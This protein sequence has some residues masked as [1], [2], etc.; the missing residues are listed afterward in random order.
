MLAAAPALVLPLL[1]ATLLAPTTPASGAEPAIPPVVWELVGV[2]T[3]GNGLLEVAEPGRYT[4]QFQSEDTVTARAGCNRVA[5]TY[6]AADGVL[7][8]A[9]SVSN[10]ARCPSDTHGASFLELLDA[11]TAFE[12]GTDGFLTFSGKEGQL[13]LRPALAGV[14]W[15]WQDFRG[16]D[17]R[18]V[19]PLRPADYTLT[20]M[21]DGK[22]EILADCVRTLGRYEVD[23]PTLEISLDSATLMECGT[24]TLADRFLRDLREVTSHIVRDGNLYLALRTDAGI[25]AFAAR[26]DERRP[27]TPPAGSLPAEPT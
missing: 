3:S 17:D 27:A 7:D 24:G 23:G 26:Y 12:M 22:L 20:F 13:Q 19:A 5:G 18:V 21:P 14:V 15:E 1:T 16:G 10:L 11:V 9:L 25:L 8:I 2:A 6:T 4:V